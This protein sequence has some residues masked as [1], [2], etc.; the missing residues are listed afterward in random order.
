M[1]ARGLP[2][3]SVRPQ[4]APSNGLQAHLTLFSLLAQQAKVRAD[5]ARTTR[6]GGQPTPAQQAEI[7]R[8]G[9]A[10]AGAREQVR[11]VGPLDKFVTNPREGRRQRDAE[12]RSQAPR[13]QRPGGPTI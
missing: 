12:R 6:S 1:P 9:K 8:L 4:V 5:L 13:Q 2:A 10:V 11:Q 3:S 7:E